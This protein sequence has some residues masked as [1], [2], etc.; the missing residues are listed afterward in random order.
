[1]HARLNRA[2]TRQRRGAA[3]HAGARS[4]QV[5]RFTYRFDE[6]AAA[7]TVSLISSRAEGAVI[8]GAT[9]VPRRKR[10]SAHRDIDFV[11]VVRS[12]RN[13]KCL[14][15]A[16]EG[17][18][19]GPL[20]D[21]IG[22]PARPEERPP[23]LPPRRWVPDAGSTR[24][25]TPPA[26]TAPPRR[27]RC[28]CAGLRG[29]GFGAERPL[30]AGAGSELVSAES[31][32]SYCRLC[33][34]SGRSIPRAGR[35]YAAPGRAG[36]AVT[37]EGSGGKAGYSR[38]ELFRCGVPVGNRREAGPVAASAHAKTEPC[39]TCAKDTFQPSYQC[40]V[41]AAIS[42]PAKA[43]RLPAYDYGQA[44][45]PFMTPYSARL[46][47][48]IFSASASSRLRSW[49]LYD[50]YR[51]GLSAPQLRGKHACSDV[52]GPKARQRPRHHP[53]G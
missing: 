30:R 18:A 42:S 7:T 16:R 26:A 13:K 24:P 6:F 28:S 50:G 44:K 45:P 48:P 34:G 37:L 29:P 12:V 38:L 1:M 47:L 8:T 15:T 10:E 33:V 31:P 4:E 46:T 5:R 43:S 41:K 17:P 53:Y 40:N 20:P 11:L 27:W 23:L 32:L 3:A 52:A 35:D 21:R 51:V 36:A 2:R 49:Q 14:S 19:A 9:Q 39:R 22:L 25:G